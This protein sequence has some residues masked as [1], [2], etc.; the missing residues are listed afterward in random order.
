MIAMLYRPKPKV[1]Q[2]TA[3]RHFKVLPIL[4]LLDLFAIHLLGDF[5]LD[6]MHFDL[7]SPSKGFVGREEASAS[8]E[9][10]KQSSAARFW[11]GQKF[12]RAERASSLLQDQR[13]RRP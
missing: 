10:I 4:L 3:D 2:R 13:V 12:V 9:R 1:R 7:V 11:D 5:L 8:F 6:I